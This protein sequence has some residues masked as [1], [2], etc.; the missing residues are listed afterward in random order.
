MSI[1]SAFIVL[2]ILAATCICDEKVKWLKLSNGCIIG[3]NNQVHTNVDNIWLCMH[4]CNTAVGFIC[5]SF[6]Y[7]ASSKKCQL[8]EDYSNSTAYAYFKVPCPYQGWEYWQRYTLG[9]RLDIPN[10]CIKVTLKNFIA[11]H[12]NIGSKNY[13]FLIC[14]FTSGCKSVNYHSG[15]QKCTLTKATYATG[16]LYVPCPGYVYVEKH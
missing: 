11:T 16:T 8:S 7:H 5:N 3:H 1:I 4:L 6:E 15:N 12:S 9:S 10:A 13:C 2:V 14:L